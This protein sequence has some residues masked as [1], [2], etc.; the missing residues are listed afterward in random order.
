MSCMEHA[1]PFSLSDETNDEEFLT[2]V[3]TF[4]MEVLDDGMGICTRPEECPDADR[5]PNDRVHRGDMVVI[6]AIVREVD[7]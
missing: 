2:I 1:K 6:V 3:S 7:G 5:H 4:V